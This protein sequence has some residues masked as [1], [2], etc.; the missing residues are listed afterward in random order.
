MFFEF[1]PI[2]HTQNGVVLNINDNAGGN[3]I[4]CTCLSQSAT[5]SFG[6]VGK[7]YLRF[8]SDVPL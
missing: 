8:I 2:V 1:P 7:Q 5:E 6:Q 4:S 3:I